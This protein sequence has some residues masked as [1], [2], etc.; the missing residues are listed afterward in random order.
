MFLGLSKEDVEKYG[1]PV[2]YILMSLLAFRSLQFACRWYL[3]GKCTFRTF[4]YFTFV[5]RNNE[6]NRNSVSLQAIPPNKKWR[7]SNEVGSLIHSVISGLWALYAV[8][9]YP[10]F[11]TDMVGY[12]HKIGLGL[13]YLS[14]GYILHDLIDLLVNE[15][16]VRI[17][18][19]LFHHVVVISAFMLTLITSKYLGL[20]VVGLFMEINSI[21]LHT[22]SLMNLYGVDKKSTSFKMIALLNIVTFMVFRNAVSIYLL[23]W[24][25]TNFFTMHII[26]ALISFIVILSLSSTNTV[27]CYRVMAADG[28]LG[29]KKTR[30]AIPTAEPLPVDEETEE[31]NGGSSAHLHPTHSVAVQVDPEPETAKL[32][33]QTSHQNI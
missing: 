9:Y 25:V 6:N 32:T 21:F 24:V 7:I 31:E 13:I 22:R 19:L 11:V 8:L 15:R 14:F 18:E 12:Q 2:V 29:K 5:G 26:I 30:S 16:S 20:A 23:Y 3:F 33:H 17:I 1:L 27:L 4:S 28:L 10:D